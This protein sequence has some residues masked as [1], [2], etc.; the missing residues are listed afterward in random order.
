MNIYIKTIDTIT[1]VYIVDKYTSFIWHKRYSDCGD[2]ELYFPYGMHP[3][4]YFNENYIITRDDDDMVCIIEK[5]EI[6]QDSE[7]SDMVLVSGRSAIALLA[8]RVQMRHVNYLGTI[9]AIL[10]TAFAENFL[11]S[12]DASRYISNFKIGKSVDDTVRTRKAFFGK[13]IYETF[14]EICKEYGL[15]EKM[16]ADEATGKFSFEIYRGSDRTENT[17]QSLKVVF[18]EEYNNVLSSSTKADI[19]EYANTAFVAGEGE[20]DARI[21][22]TY[23]SEAAS[24]LKRYEV[25]VDARDVRKTGEGEDAKTLSDEEYDALLQSEGLQEITANHSVAEEI[26]FEVTTAGQFVYGRD[27]SVGDIVI[28]QPKHTTERRARVAGVTESFDENGY[29]I[30]PELELEGQNNG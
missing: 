3:I 26:A 7:G 23:Q 24:G 9:A 21:T 29:S 2:F 1:P 8:R 15:G 17:E 6:S 14:S 20:G 16:T 27:Y 25:F 18:S 5:V 12:R 4:E 19:T 11:D 28:V 22:G 30:L 10:Q 13:N